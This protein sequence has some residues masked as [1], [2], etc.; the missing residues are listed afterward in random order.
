VEHFQ[1]FDLP[2]FNTKG[3]GWCTANLRARFMLTY[4]FS[5][6]RVAGGSTSA[7]YPSLALLRSYVETDAVVRKQSA[8]AL[9]QDARTHKHKRRQAQT[10]TDRHRQTHRHTDIQTHSHKDTQTHRHT[11][12]QRD[13]DR[14][15]DRDTYTQVYPR[16]LIVTQ[17]MGAHGSTMGSYPWAHIGD[18]GEGRGNHWYIG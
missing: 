4:V 15:R 3:G 6:V 8:A 11:G 18:E 17:I 10:D 1:V 14:D 5:S 16:V 7:R 13:K 12:R 2:D 9:E